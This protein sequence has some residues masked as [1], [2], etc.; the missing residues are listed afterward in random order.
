MCSQEREGGRSTRTCTCV[1]RCVG[2]G[3][4]VRRMGRGYWD[5]GCV[6]VSLVVICTGSR[7]LIVRNAIALKERVLRLDVV[8]DLS[9]R[10]P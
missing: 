1:G 3:I 4:A 5:T 9:L 2:D 6:A 7:M 8:L 10:K